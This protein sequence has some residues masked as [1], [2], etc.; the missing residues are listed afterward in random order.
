MLDDICPEIVDI[1]KDKTVNPQTF[2]ILRKLKPMRQI[3]AAEL[4]VTAGNWTSS[5]AKALLAA[6]KQDVLAAPGLQADREFLRR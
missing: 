4:M 3:E 5:Y 2:E 6:T 1:L